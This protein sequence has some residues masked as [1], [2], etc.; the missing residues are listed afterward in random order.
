MMDWPGVKQCERPKWK[1]HLV[2][3][4]EKQPQTA[5]SIIFTETRISNMAGS[6]WMYLYIHTGW[7]FRPLRKI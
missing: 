6:C 1:K 3:L 5:F 7:W 4:F 2:I